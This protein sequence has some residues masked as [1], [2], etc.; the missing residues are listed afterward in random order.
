M[1][2]VDTRE[3]GE[4]LLTRLCHDLAGPLGAVD[5]G[6]EFLKEDNPDLRDKS[7]ELIALS[8][9]EAIDRMVFFRQTFGRTAEGNTLAWEDIKKIAG[10]Y[11]GQRHITLKW[12]IDKKNE[13]KPLPALE[14]KCLFLLLLAASDTLLSGGTI[15]CTYANDRLHIH[16]EGKPMKANPTLP[17]LLKKDKAAPAMDVKNAS[18][19]YT[20]CIAEQLKAK[21]KAE[22]T[23]LHY[24]IDATF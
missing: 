22:S 4:M 10:Q 23:E 18:L 12:K 6:I 24:A 19:F 8:V 7:M 3:L 13:G 5:N 2:A 9:R 14:V 16:A 17:L 11:F 20:L 15:A 1:I 21:I